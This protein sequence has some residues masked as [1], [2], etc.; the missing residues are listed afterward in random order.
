MTAEK[1]VWACT[2]KLNLF[3]NTQLQNLFWNAVAPATQTWHFLSV[4]TW[5]CSSLE[6]ETFWLNSDPKFNRKLPETLK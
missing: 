6:V 2:G 5:H 1:D 3:S 4:F